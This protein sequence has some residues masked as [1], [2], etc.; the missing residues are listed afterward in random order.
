[1][2]TSLTDYG[3]ACSNVGY[4][5][6]RNAAILRTE[7]EYEHCRIIVGRASAWRPPWVISKN[8]LI[9]TCWNVCRRC[10]RFPRDSQSNTLTSEKQGNQ[11]YNHRDSDRIQGQSE[12]GRALCV[13]LWNGCCWHSCTRILL[14]LEENNKS[15]R[16]CLHRMRWVFFPYS[17]L[18]KIPLRGTWLQWWDSDLLRKK[19]WWQSRKK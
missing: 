15:I 10:M 7:D 8:H 9:S 1:M 13:S 12:F 14:S 4:G 11:C 2:L 3:D 19:S 6:F 18:A 17:Y 16:F 5:T